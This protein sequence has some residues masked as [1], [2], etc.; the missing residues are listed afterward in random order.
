MTE[1]TRDGVTETMTSQVI[2]ILFRNAIVARVRSERRL[3]RILL[4][5]FVLASVVAILGRMYGGLPLSLCFSAILALFAEALFQ[6]HFAEAYR[7]YDAWTNFRRHAYFT[8][9]TFCLSRL[10][11]G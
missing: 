7:L 9:A 5:A 8:G 3:L 4:E 10:V 1:R 2:G 11:V 6:V